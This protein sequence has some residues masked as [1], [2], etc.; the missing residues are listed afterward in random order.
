MVRTET[1]L[2]QRSLRRWGKTV[3]PQLNH[4]LKTS[5]QPTE[6]GF[7]LNGLYTAGYHGNAQEENPEIMPIL[8][9]YI[10]IEV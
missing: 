8:H 7:I 4:E 3:R 5:K 10:A 9:S 1:S 6:K 2:P